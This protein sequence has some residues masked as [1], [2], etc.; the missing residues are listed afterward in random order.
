MR[1][2]SSALIHIQ[3][4]CDDSPKIR[5]EPVIIQSSG[6]IP[7]QDLSGGERKYDDM[8]KESGCQDCEEVPRIGLVRKMRDCSL[9][10]LA[11]DDAW[12]KNNRQ[13][14]HGFQRRRQIHDLNL[15]LGVAIERAA[16]LYQLPPS[17]RAASELCFI[18]NTAVERWFWNSDSSSGNRYT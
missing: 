11:K 1:L 13:N 3:K 17:R 8:Q 18:F 14:Q 15:F 16:I 6:E 9:D 2:I 10:K 5:E 4:D 7:I 12:H